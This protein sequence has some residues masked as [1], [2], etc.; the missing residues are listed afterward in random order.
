VELPGDV[1]LYLVEALGT[2]TGRIEGELE[3][4]ICYCGGT[5]QGISLAA[6]QEICCS[7]GEAVSWALRDAVGARDLDAALGLIEVLLQ[8]EKDPEGAVLGLVSQVA[9]QFRQMLQLRVFMQTRKLRSVADCTARAEALTESE[10]EECVAQGIEVVR[11]HPFRLKVLARQALS[12]NGTE[13]TAAVIAARDTYWR[14]VSSAVG[15][16]VLLEE[17]LMRLLAGGGKP[18]AGPGARMRRA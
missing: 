3:K 13:L 9:S 16:R 5:G 10:R 11:L 4:L 8:R 12:Y 2:D 18:A 6:A 17:L 1:C 14:C 7:Q 15:K